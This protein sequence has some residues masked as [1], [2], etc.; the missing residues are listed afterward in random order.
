MLF[1]GSHAHL[2]N[3]DGLNW[4]L[5]DVAPLLDESPD[6]C[7]LTIVGSGMENYVP[8]EGSG[9]RVDIRGRVDDAAL[10]RCYLES[11]LVIAPLRFGGGVKGKVLEAIGHGV[12]C[13]MT[14]PAAQGLAGIESLLPVVDDPGGYARA[15]EQLLRDDDAWV[16]AAKA[17]YRFL[18]EHYDPRRFIERLKELLPA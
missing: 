13:V 8:P 10:L 17:A 2:P 9:I 12:P 4:F 16:A 7:A 11:R 5:R 3:I 1:V 14:S 15:L 18:E 6:Q